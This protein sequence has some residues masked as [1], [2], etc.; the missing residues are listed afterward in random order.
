MGSPHRGCDLRTCDSKRWRSK[1]HCD[2]FLRFRGFPRARACVQV[3]GIQ[4]TQR[5]AFAF[6][7]PLSPWITRKMALATEMSLSLIPVAVVSQK[8]LGPQDW[9]GC[10]GPVAVRVCVVCHALWLGSY[11]MRIGQD[12]GACS[13]RACFPICSSVGARASQGG[14]SHFGP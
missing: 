11:V 9:S 8:W 5:F 10:V 14:H 4:K 2:Y 12:S 13:E 6:L 7:S 3:L 1:T